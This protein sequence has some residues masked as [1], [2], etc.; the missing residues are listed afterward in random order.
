MS[1]EEKFDCII[2]GAGPAGLSAAITLAKAGVEVAVLERGEYPGAKNVMGGILF[3][4][5]LDK[6][7]PDFWEKAPVERHITHRRFSLLSK[8]SEI[9]LDFKTA[10]YNEPPYNHTW[11]V[12]RAKFD[13]W[14]AEQV[15]EA[16]AM[17]IPGMM[18]SE[19]LMDGDRVVGVK[20][21][22]GGDELN[23]DVVISAEGVNSFL[24]EQAGLR[25]Q[26]DPAHMAV[27]VKEVISLPQ[28][29]I[30][31]RF[32]LNDSEG[33]AYEI[34][35]QAVQG[36]FG[37]GFVYTNKD[38]LSIG[39]GSTIHDMKRHKLNP[40]DVL[41]GFKKHPAIAPLVR[42]AESQEYA[43]HMI[44][45]GGFHHLPKLT[46][47]GLILTG[48]AAGLIN[49]SH[50]HE[51]SNLA[52]AS[53]VMAAETVI[54]AKEKGDFS[55]ASLSTY[56]QK[57][58]DSFVLKDL[59]KFQNL[60]KF[61]NENPH[62]LRDY[63]DIISGMLKDYFTISEKPKAV[64]EKEVMAKFKKEIGIWNI[65]KDLYKIWRAMR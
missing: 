2:V 13:R 16:G 26:H 44:P 11:S 7:L 5:I 31:D 50:Y 40:N 58:D 59:K 15:E 22:P 53:G 17:I 45:E 4:T 19:L 55:D 38:S 63:P 60:S 47:N 29:T 3:T 41:E 46:T 64:I 61:L 14:F 65:G 37:S 25:K 23:C 18:V 57:L 36:T 54:A 34:F 21:E 33:C 62:L 51:G 43:A 20:T 6:L 48:D 42:G 49:A 9:A 12:L 10:G 30:E 35:G 52:M 27:A 8:D 39:V 24:A 56:R 28:E 32:H 1:E